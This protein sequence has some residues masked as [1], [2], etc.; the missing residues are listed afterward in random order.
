MDNGE[1][2]STNITENKNGYRLDKDE[3]ISGYNSYSRVLQN[4]VSISTNFLKAFISNQSKDTVSID[5]TESPLFTNNVKVG[6]I[7]A[8]KKIKK[9]VLRNRAKRLLKEAYRLNKYHFRIFQS[10]TNIVFSLTDNG[11]QHF[12]ENQNEKLEFIDREMKSLSDKIKKK[13]NK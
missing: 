4:A 1:N 7:I 2:Q 13:F 6:F 10:K 8:K 9:A 5:S 11:Y 3:I 12:I